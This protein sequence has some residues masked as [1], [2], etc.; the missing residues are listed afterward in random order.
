MTMRDAWRNEHALIR[1]GFWHDKVHLRA[2][3]IDGE[4]RRCHRLYQEVIDSGMRAVT[5]Y[6]DR[7]VETTCSRLAA[8]GERSR[9][10]AREQVS[11]LFSLL[12]LNKSRA[13]AP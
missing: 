4:R 7:L 8:S 12:A 13:V 5:R 10:L 2:D 1:R 3:E 6:T 9:G 11:N